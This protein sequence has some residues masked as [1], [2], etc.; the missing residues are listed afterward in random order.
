MSIR[1]NVGHLSDLDSPSQ[2]PA[3]SG[4]EVECDGLA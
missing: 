4:A 3:R 2:L 1:M